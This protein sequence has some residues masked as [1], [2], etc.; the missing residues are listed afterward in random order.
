MIIP[1]IAD[2]I[3][4]NTVSVETTSDSAFAFVGGFSGYL[5]GAMSNCYSTSTILSQYLDTKYFVGT[6]LGLAYIE[7]WGNVP[8]P[9]MR[10]RDTQLHHNYRSSIFDIFY[11]ES[12]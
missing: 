12:I 8:D 10:H 7:P 6:C 9:P 4:D 5:Y 3:V 1:T 2:C 11:L